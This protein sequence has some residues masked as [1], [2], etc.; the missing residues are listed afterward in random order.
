MDFAVLLGKMLIFSVVMLL[1][2]VFARRG[3][4]DSAFA[5]STSMLVMTVFLPATIL[6]SVFTASA[7]PDLAALMKLLALTTLSLAVGY[8]IAALA[9]RLLPIGKDAQRSSVFELLIGLSN[10][11]FIGLPVAQSLYG[12]EAVFYCALSCIP[13]NLYSYTYGVWRLTGGGKGRLRV[14]D[15]LSVPLLA[16]LV[17]VLVFFFRLP[18]P[19]LVKELAGALSGATMPMSL[20]VIGFSMGSVSLADAFKNKPL[21]L[22]SLLRLIV[23]P[24]LVWLLVRC[25]TENIVLLTT[26]MLLAASPSA[27]MVSVFAIQYKR[28]SLFAAE[29]VLQS[30]VLSMATI[31]LLLLVLGG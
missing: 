4:V 7:S 6:N 10:T 30:T 31:P 9:V 8:L 16:T 2:Y 24:V 14:K 27:V 29:G 25:F 23:A 17:A 3:M 20:L 13:F 1:G 22:V 15:I 26:C 5:R 19:G 12:S 18:V 28:D 11:M 21:Y